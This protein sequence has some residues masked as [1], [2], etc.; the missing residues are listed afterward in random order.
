[1]I[2]CNHNR[3]EYYFDQML[4]YHIENINQ[5][6]NA[7]LEMIYTD[8]NLNR[9]L[10]EQVKVFLQHSGIVNFSYCKINPQGEYSI[11]MTYSFEEMSAYYQSQLWLVDHSLDFEDD[12]Y[13]RLID[14]NDYPNIKSSS[15]YPYV[16]DQVVIMIQ[17][18]IFGIK[19]AFHFSLRRVAYHSFMKTGQT[20]LMYSVLES[21]LKWLYASVRMHCAISLNF[22]CYDF[23][24]Q[25]SIKQGDKAL[26]ESN[27]VI[28]T[29]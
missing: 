19:Y 8:S 13:F 21:V 1:M 18:V 17:H 10:L 12:L 15:Y 26:V 22:D 23:N 5:L 11:A 20:Y 4:T 2:W 3:I 14:Y 7:D 27:G 9:E 16:K 25:P 6:S 24:T 28:L 29:S